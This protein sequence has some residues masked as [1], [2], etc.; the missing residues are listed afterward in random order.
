MHHRHTSPAAVFTK[1]HAFYSRLGEI[2][3]AI[4]VAAGL[5]VDAL[6]GPRP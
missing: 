3:D 4:G 6:R 5:A 2:D 1:A